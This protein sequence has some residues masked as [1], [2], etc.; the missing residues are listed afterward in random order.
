MDIIPIGSWWGHSVSRGPGGEAWLDGMGW[1]VDEHW[2]W[3]FSYSLNEGEWMWTYE[4]GGTPEGFFAYVPKGYKWIFIN[5]MSGWYYDYE[6]AS[7]K[8]LETV[9]P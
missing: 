5:A 7:W 8:V 4:E 1:V 2:P 9:T 6:S 3:V